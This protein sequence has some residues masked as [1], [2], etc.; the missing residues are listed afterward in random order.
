MIQKV[1]RPIDRLNLLWPPREAVFDSTVFYLLTS[2]CFVELLKRD[3]TVEEREGEEATGWCCSGHRC[4]HDAPPRQFALK[5]GFGFVLI[6]TS[7]DG[8]ACSLKV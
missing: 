8:T 6:L 7:G 5:R 4:A 2:L 3:L 1:D